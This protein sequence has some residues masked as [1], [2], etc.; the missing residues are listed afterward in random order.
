[1]RPPSPF[2]ISTSSIFKRK[3]HT[4]ICFGENQLSPSL[5]GVSPLTT[6]HPS[7]FPRTPVRTSIHL[8]VDFTLFMVSSLGFGSNITDYSPFLR[9]GFPT[10]PLLLQIKLAYNINS[11][12]HSSIS[13]VLPYKRAL[14]AC[15]HAVSGSISLP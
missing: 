6:N 8:S 14:Q 7:A 4:Y 15:L 10:P 3:G 11:L 9:L 1:M 12:D 2:S 5:L 13:T